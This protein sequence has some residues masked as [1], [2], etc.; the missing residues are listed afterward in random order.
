MTPETSPSSP[1][2]AGQPRTPQGAMAREALIVQVDAE[3]KNLGTLCLPPLKM[4]QKSLLRFRSEEVADVNQTW[5]TKGIQGVIERWGAERTFAQAPL[6]SAAYLAAPT[7]RDGEL[8]LVLA[9]SEFVPDLTPSAAQ[10]A[11]YRSRNFET[12]ET[13]QDELRE[14]LRNSGI[15]ERFLPP[16]DNV[17]NAQLSRAAIDSINCSCHWYGDENLYGNGTVLEMTLSVSPSGGRPEH[18]RLRL[19]KFGVMTR[20]LWNEEFMETGYDGH[21]HLSQPMLIKELRALLP[22][23]QK[24]QNEHPSVQRSLYTAA[25]IPDSLVAAT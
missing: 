10:I 19:D 17:A 15:L 18:I 3:L 8:P 21:A 1:P 22:I 23:V 25:W 11:Y 13:F 12:S 16:S 24:L 9:I 4:R 20:S 7:A 14:A 2:L 5:E 6:S